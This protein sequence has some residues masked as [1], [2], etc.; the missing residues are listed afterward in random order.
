MKIE[1]TGYSDDLIEVD[2][3]LRLEF[4]NIKWDKGLIVSNEH[5]ESVIVDLIFDDNGVWRITHNGK[6]SPNWTFELE[7]APENDDDDY[8]DKLTIEASGKLFVGVY[9]KY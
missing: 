7:K 1:I 9:D 5:G 6:N 3:D 8:T 4:D 2:G